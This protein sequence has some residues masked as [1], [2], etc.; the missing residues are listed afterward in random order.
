MDTA[1]HYLDEI[2]EPAIKDLENSPTS[3]R[4]AFLACV[5]TVHTVDDIG[6]SVGETTP[7]LRQILRK[8]SE[9]FALV[10]AVAH[11][12]KH[13]SACGGAQLKATEQPRP[14]TKPSRII[15]LTFLIAVYGPD[16]VRKIFVMPVISSEVFMMPAPQRPWTS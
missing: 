15:A 10:D 14:P 2:V 5:V 7:H 9:D 3:A 1:T 13:V 11:G 4:H 6:R 16:G 12:F 8:E